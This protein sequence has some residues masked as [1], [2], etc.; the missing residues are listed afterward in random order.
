MVLLITWPTFYVVYVLVSDT[1]FR[2]IKGLARIH[3]HLLSITLGIV[4]HPFSLLLS[5][6]DLR[7][8]SRGQGFVAFSITI[9]MTV[10]LSG[11]LRCVH[12]E[13]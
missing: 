12:L 11:V 13:V 4:H 9:P 5:W 3:H 8:Y 1:R 6:P 7:A 2:R 10:S